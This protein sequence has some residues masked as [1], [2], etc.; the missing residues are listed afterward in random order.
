MYKNTNVSI[1]NIK[2]DNKISIWSKKKISI[3]LFYRQNLTGTQVL[4]YYSI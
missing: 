1:E 2:Y 4:F 3:I